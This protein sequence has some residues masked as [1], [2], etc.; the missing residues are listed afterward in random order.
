M[1]SSLVAAATVLRL[2]WRWLQGRA[3]EQDK[4]EYRLMVLKF[5]SATRFLVVI[6]IIGLALTASVLFVLAGFG[7]IAFIVES[8]LELFSGHAEELIPIIQLVE[9]VH[10]FLVGTVLYIT[11]IG[12]YQ[13]FVNPVP[14]PGW[15]QIDSPDE[16]EGSLI[17]VTVVVLAVNF[18]GVVVTRDQ[19]INT[20]QYG[21]GIAL[22]IAALALFVGLRAFAKWLSHR[23]AQHEAN[24]AADEPAS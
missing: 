23:A 11:A 6:P 5:V 21:A 13:L 18:L 8:A 20:L 16:L 14:M 2:V 9:F 10:Q 7:L 24:A 1:F 4:G 15:L 3:P 22:P 12:L 19:Q 17:S